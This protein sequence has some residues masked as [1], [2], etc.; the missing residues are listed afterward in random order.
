MNQ[1]LISPSE[2]IA[3]RLKLRQALQ[4][5]IPPFSLLP[6]PEP[7][8][9][10]TV[11]YELN[12]AAFQ[13]GKRHSLNEGGTSSS[14]TYSILQILILL[15]SRQGLL[16]SVVSESLPHLK[17]GAIRDFRNLMGAK[18]DSRLYNKSEH[19]Y[20]F[21]KGLIEFFP[22]DEP[23]KLRGGRRDILF[24]NEANNVSWDAFMELDS[25]TRLFTFLD[26]NPVSEFWAH[27]KGLASQTQNAYIH[28]TYQDALA[29]LYPEVVANIEAN[30]GLDMNWW[31]VFGLG[32]LGKKEGLVFPSFSQVEQL[33]QGGQQF[34]GL[35][36]GYS[37]DPTALVKCVLEK[38]GLYCQE[39]IY[40]TGL[41]NDAIA[42][43]MGEL[44]VKK[45]YDEIFADAAEPKSIEEIH[46]YGFNIKPCPK[47]AD[48]VEYGHQKLRQFKHFWTKASLACIKEQRNYRYIEDKDGKLTQKTTHLFSHGM[49]ARR[50]AVVG[51]LG[52]PVIESVVNQ[53]KVSRWRD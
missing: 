53:V 47:G 30:K 7:S 12:A 50:Y 3:F 45:N 19:I 37:A 48:S 36:F 40:E 32:R 9:K 21:G 35:D 4:T 13:S 23:G 28:S 34:F 17:R 33:P 8:F 1:M 46:R 39:F 10:T 51:Y 2:L 43:R 26:W 14:K 27:E 52:H 20:N 31:N 11:V 41:T 42:L 6:C 16:C 5:K 24:L 22:A 49:D 15:A 38:D 25:R 44:G 18:Y 29:V